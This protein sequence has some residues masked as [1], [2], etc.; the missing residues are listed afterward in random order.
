MAKD[1]KAMG[2]EDELYDMIDSENDLVDQEVDEELDTEDDLMNDDD[3]MMID[4]VADGE[5]ESDLLESA[6]PYYVY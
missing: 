1:K 6:N 2:L 3:G 4:I 5:T